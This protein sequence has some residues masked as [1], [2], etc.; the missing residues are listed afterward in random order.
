MGSE[1]C[2]RDSYL[3]Y[4]VNNV[5]LAAVI[6]VLGIVVDDAII[7]AEN[8]SRKRSQGLSAIDASV[9]GTSQVL[10]PIIASILTT[11][12]AFLPFFF[13]EGRFSSFVKYIPAIV[14]LMLMG[15]LFESLFILPSHLQG[16]SNKTSEAKGHW[17]FAV[18]KQFAKILEVILKFRWA[19]LIGFIGILFASIYILKGELKFVL[20]PKG[21]SQEVYIRATA[22]NSKNA[23]ETAELS[24]KIEA[25]LLEDE[26][27][28][29]GVRT[30]IGQSRRG[31]RASET[32]A[33]FRIEL[34]P[35]EERSQSSGAISDIWQEKL[36]SLT[37]FSKARVVRGHFGFSS[38]S[39]LEILIQ[40]ND[41]TNRSNIAKRIEE[42]MNAIEGVHNVEIEAPLMEKSY[43]IG[44]NKKRMSQLGLSPQVIANSI[45]SFV[46]GQVLF[47]LPE[48]DQEI[49]VRLSSTQTTRENIEQLLAKR[50]GNSSGYLVPLKEIITINEVNK[51]S[52]ISRRD[53]QRTT[54]VYGDLKNGTKVTPLEIAEKI[55]KEVFPEILKDYP[56]ALIRFTGEVEESRN[57]RSGF[58]TSIIMAVLLIYAILIILFNSMTTPFL[59]LATIPFGLAGV[60]IAFYLH[61]KTSFGFFA[62]VG[63]IGM[64]GV[65][66]NDS[67]VLLSLIHI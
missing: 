13:F 60:I 24:R 45:R 27:L 51:P 41:N 12:V 22:D 56:S 48:G 53:Y 11:C 42:S 14:T 6:I 65:V 26:S 16:W 43:E 9:Q 3:G 30:N 33:S 52:T 5:T 50:V 34:S 47:T 4:T 37:D 67:I 61:Q 35:K 2:I 62:V 32:S 25:M 18:E 55:E 1:M 7:V 58:T 31:R 57:S 63:S 10:F 36:K 44:F 46:A 19:Y 20:F 15:S 40:E 54:E 49:E 39:P 59:I 29:L 28:V 17:F 8:V 21:E 66:I 38:G 64:S 23:L